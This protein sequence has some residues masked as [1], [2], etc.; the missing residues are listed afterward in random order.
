[1]NETDRIIRERFQMKRGDTLPYTGKARTTRNDL[2]KLFAELKFQ[3]GAEI[4]VCKGEYSVVLLRENPECQ[5]KLVDPYQPYV[6]PWNFKVSQE[7]QDRR[8]EKARER[9]APYPNIEFIRKTSMEAVRDVPD[10]S[11]DFIF[12][13][14]LHDFD[15]IMLDLIYWTKKVRPSGICAGHDYFYMADGQ[16]PD[17]VNSYTHAHL[18]RDWYITTGEKD[19]SWFWVKR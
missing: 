11:L 18:I 8:L 1:M 17:A 15:S 16:V 2:A 5:L 3:S 4:G 10:G 14:G 19:A 12:L 13:D 9:L 6:S 7:R